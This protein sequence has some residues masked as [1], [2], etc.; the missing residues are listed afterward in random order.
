METAENVSYCVRSYILHEM[1][2]NE[3]EFRN[4]VKINDQRSPP[5]DWDTLPGF[6]SQHTCFDSI[7][8]CLERDRYSLLFMQMLIMN[9]LFY[10][11]SKHNRTSIAHTG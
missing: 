8:K 7:H 4:V 11:S 3:M 6:V 10:C 2:V 1:Q 5:S 9:V